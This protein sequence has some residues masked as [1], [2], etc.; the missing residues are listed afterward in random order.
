MHIFDG[1]EWLGIDRVYS[2]PYMQTSKVK[3]RNDSQKVCMHI[4]ENVMLSL[5]KVDNRDDAL[6]RLERVCEDGGIDAFLNQTS[7]TTST[8]FTD[9]FA[10]R[11]LTPLLEV[12]YG[13]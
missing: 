3:D 12:L 7:D 1:L 6:F 4:F 9:T 5:D 13:L 2:L 8:N 11:L 10:V